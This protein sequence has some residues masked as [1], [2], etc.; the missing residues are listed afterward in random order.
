VELAKQLG[1]ATKAAEQLG[2]SDGNIYSWQQKVQQGLSLEH[3][4]RAQ[5]LGSPVVGG[6]SPEEE[7]R[8]LRRENVDLKKANYILKA[9]A[10]FFSQDHLK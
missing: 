1:S 5:P 8:R 7:L 3:G 9:A 6:E 2:I 4:G 10:A